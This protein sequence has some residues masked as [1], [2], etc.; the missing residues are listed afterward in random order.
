ML[1]PDRAEKL[2]DKV[3]GL[4]RER[5]PVRP[6][7]DLTVSQSHRIWL[8]FSPYNFSFSCSVSRVIFRS[9][10]QNRMLSNHNAPREASLKIH[11]EIN[12]WIW[13]AYLPT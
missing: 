11:I 3:L 8:V 12:I 9:Y 5:P 2:A 1:V 10:T 4:L 7:D 13:K 6:T